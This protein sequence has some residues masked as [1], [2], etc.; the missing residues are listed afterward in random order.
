MKKGREKGRERKEERKEAREGGTRRNPDT[1]VLPVAMVK[2]YVLETISLKVGALCH[3]LVVQV[4]QLIRVY[5]L[6]NR[7]HEHIH[8]NTAEVK[9][10]MVY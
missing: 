8:S 3:C 6:G 4:V 7:S 9:G 2:V 1:H 10:Q 5:L